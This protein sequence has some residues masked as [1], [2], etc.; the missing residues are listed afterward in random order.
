M[1]VTQRLTLRELRLKDARAVATGAGDPRVAQNLMQ[2]PSPYPIALARAWVR[3]RIDWR[4]SGRGVTLGIV[5]TTAPDTVLGTV[6]L[7]RHL[8]DRRAELGYWLD[9]AAWGQGFATEAVQAAVDFGFRD[10]KLA[11]IYAH[12]LAG[13][14]ASMRVLAKVGMTVEGVQ[15]QHV[16]K[17]GRLQDL[18]IYGLLAAE[19]SGATAARR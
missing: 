13:N 7:R 1:L 3:D 16:M 11:R 9:V 10:L 6:S 8:R 2:V 14:L 18:A 19:W 5:A 15:R 4:E 12:V 17:H